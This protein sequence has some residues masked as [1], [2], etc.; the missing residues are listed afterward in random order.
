MPRIPWLILLVVLAP[1]T[2]P[3]ETIATVVEARSDLAAIASFFPR[4]EGSEGEK[5]LVGYIA[6]RLTSLGI[7][8]SPFD[9]RESDF[10]HS[11]SSCVRVDMP[12]SGPDTLILAVPLDQP[13]NSAPGDDGA[14][15]VAIALQLLRL[16]KEKPSP[17]SVTVLFLGAEFGE[18]DL[19]PMGSRLF[20]K[21]FQPA[22][23]AAV[24]YL[25]LRRIP[26]RVLVR[27]GAKGIVS[28]AWL[29]TWCAEALGRSKV[30]YMLYGD[31]AQVFRLGLTA[32][33]E[34]I[35]PYLKAGYP[36]VGLEGEYGPS[37]PPRAEEWIGSFVSSLSGM[38]D[39]SAAGMPEEWDRHYLLFPAGGRTL[40]VTERVYLA[41]LFSSLAGM[42]LFS[43]LFGRGLKKYLRTLARN[44]PALIPLAGLYFLFLLTATFA[45][46]WLLSQRRFA[47]L[48]MHAPLAF[49]GL[50]ACIALV[51]YSVFFVALRRLP[52]P[53]KGSFYSASALFFLLVDIVV[54][55]ALN[56]TF[57][58]YFL[59]A[60]FFVFLATLA[61]GRVAKLLLALPAPFWGARGLLEVFLLPAIPFC[62]ILLFSRVWGNLLIV[63]ATFPFLLVLLRLGLMYRGKGLARRGRREII[64]GAVAFAAT[65]ALSVSLYLFSPFSPANPQSL[66]A[67]QTIDEEKQEGSLEI[68]SE[69]P[70]GELIVSDASGDRRIDISTSVFSLPLAAVPLPLSVGMESSEFLGKMNV[71]LRIRMP[72]SPRSLSM[73]LTSEEDFIL[74]DCSFP[75]VRESPREYRL[76]VGAFPPNPLPLQL[77]FP[78]GGR[79]SLTMAIDMD[80][81]LIGARIV[82]K[83]DLRVK[84]RVHLVKRLDVR[85]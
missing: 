80:S 10:Q 74:Y 1:M 22:Y 27:G 24:I 50:K 53:R 63:G 39:A 42:L 75:T 3:A 73:T 4:T 18:G 84:T 76:L 41:V 15:N 19:Y 36:A 68:S 44:F 59:W 64:F 29:L 35:G 62:R 60:Y 72:S 7:S 14:V 13:P 30:P 69:A 78:T 70:P 49:L 46:E 55:A 12:G 61:R 77:T 8:S 23:K 81:P 65:A 11:F 17:L 71:S 82:P 56:V 66:L 28:P 25:N 6:S 34:Q 33:K 45:I 37:A 48:W 67:T 57:S 16:L 9:F 58:Y 43:L 26:A 51:L 47:T 21:D 31:E 32:E 52:F 54:A 2:L 83:G 5:A 85:T 20:L 79:F 40:V 38:A